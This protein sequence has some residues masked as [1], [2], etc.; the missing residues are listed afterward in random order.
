MRRRFFWSSQSASLLSGSGGGSNYSG[1]FRSCCRG[2]CGYDLCSW[3]TLRCSNTH[4]SRDTAADDDTDDNGEG[5][6]NDYYC[7]H[8]T[9]YGSNISTTTGSIG[10]YSIETMQYYYSQS[11][12]YL[13]C[14]TFH[15]RE[16]SRIKCILVHCYVVIK[17]QMHAC[18][19]VTLIG[20]NWLLQLLCLAYFTCKDK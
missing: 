3:T 18:T 20:C 13:Y 8:S 14:F 2:R 6:D 1:S 17:Y 12:T 15:T 16:R 4:T 9:N 7:N 5:D 10:C 11:W 19:Q